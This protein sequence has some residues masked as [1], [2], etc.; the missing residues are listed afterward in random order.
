MARYVGIPHNIEAGP[1]PNTTSI[2]IHCLLLCRIKV[3]CPN[4]RGPKGEQGQGLEKESKRKPFEGEHGLKGEGTQSGA[5][6]A[7]KVP[8]GEEES[9]GRWSD[10]LYES[11]LNKIP[12]GLLSLKVAIFRCML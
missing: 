8:R 6:L 5:I 9:E 2:W 1:N 10:P 3:A 4:K 11:S 7:A 12:P